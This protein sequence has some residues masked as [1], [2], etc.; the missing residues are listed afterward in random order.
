MATT[1]EASPTTMKWWGWGDPA[2][3]VELPPRALERLRS[4]L[5]AAGGRSEPVPLDDVRLKEPHLT[6]SAAQRLVRIVGNAGF[7]DDRQARVQHAAG[8]GYPDL[9]RMRAGSAED[10]PDA[11]IYPESAAQVKAVLD[12]CA[13]AGIAVVPFGGGTSVVGGVEPLRGPFEALV[14][15]DLARMGGVD[16]D[17]R[18]LTASVGP[19]LRGPQLE[20]TLA[21]SDL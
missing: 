5:G 8:K 3:R 10:A 17:L 18:S 11:V 9:I 20:A 12:L 2:R 19:G 7:R 15:L 16:V 6:D 21:R 4:V 13:E 14:A 1:V